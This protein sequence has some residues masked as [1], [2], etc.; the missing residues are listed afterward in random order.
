[1]FLMPLD[2]FQGLKLEQIIAER[3]LSSQNLNKANKKPSQIIVN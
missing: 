3:D 2:K 1:M